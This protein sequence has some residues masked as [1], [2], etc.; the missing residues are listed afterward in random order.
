LGKHRQSVQERLLNFRALV[1][2]LDKTTQKQTYQSKAPAR[3]GIRLVDQEVID[4]IVA[5]KNAQWL[6]EISH[7]TDP[8]EIVLEFGGRLPLPPERG[9]RTRRSAP[10][11]YWGG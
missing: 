9:Y 4:G 3:L 8:Y 5:R 11:F 2:R 1:N 7:G 10:V 6:E